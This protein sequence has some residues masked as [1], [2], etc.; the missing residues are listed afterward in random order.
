MFLKPLLYYS[1]LLPSLNSFHYFVSFPLFLRH[2]LAEILVYFLF[3]SSICRL[4]FLYLH[5]FEDHLQAFL[6]FADGF[7]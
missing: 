7:L 2:E 4:I 3:L 5:I 1:V 6:S